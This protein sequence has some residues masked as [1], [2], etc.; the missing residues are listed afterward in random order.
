MGVIS[1]MERTLNRTTM[2]VLVLALAAG[3]LGGCSNPFSPPEGDPIP[4]PPPERTSPQ[5]VLLV[6]TRSYE[7]MSA[8]DYLDCLA[9]EFIFYTAEADQNDPNNPLPEDWDKQTERVIHE[10][11]FAEGTDVD[12]ITLT[13]TNQSIDF[14]PGPDPEDPLDDRY[15]YVEAVDLRVFIPIPGDD[16]ILLATANN[17][18]VFQIDPNE[19]SSEGEP[20]WEI[21]E[22]HDLDERSGGPV[23]EGPA[24]ELASV[25]RVKTHSL[26]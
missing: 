12:R 10:N 16:L 13:L 6:L 19:L 25:G 1:Q 5:N 23:H 8:Q 20:L 17:M 14:I 2:L 22:W 15:A 9:E 18:F 21:V 24:T 26:E 11:M 7:D 3:S 4:N